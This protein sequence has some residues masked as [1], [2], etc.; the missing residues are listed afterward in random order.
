M[1]Q[2][3]IVIVMLH[4]RVTDS[5]KQVLNQKLSLASSR[6]AA[7]SMQQSD[8]ADIEGKDVQAHS[9]YESFGQ[10]QRGPSVLRFS[11]VPDIEYTPDLAEAK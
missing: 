8:D 10:G 5:C 4:P 6:R 1:V 7:H 2:A 11:K 9:R 3:F